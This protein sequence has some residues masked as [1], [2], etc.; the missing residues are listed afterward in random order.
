LGDRR[1]E[2]EAR[3]AMREMPDVGSDGGPELGGSKWEIVAAS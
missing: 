1:W 3:A 2:R